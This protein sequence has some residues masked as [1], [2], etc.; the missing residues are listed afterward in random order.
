MNRVFISGHKFQMAVLIC[1]FVLLSG[2][3]TLTSGRGWGEDV[4]LIKWHQIKLALVNAA[5][6]PETW[7]PL[8]GAMVFSIDDLDE[9]TSDWLSKETP[10]FGSNSAASDA[11]SYLKEALNL[12]KVGA[13]LATPSGDAVDEWVPSR[14]V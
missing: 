8:A 14:R 9:D 11:S 10:V 6:D 4:S 2:C 7:V 12:I 5:K 13:A 1:L 3:S